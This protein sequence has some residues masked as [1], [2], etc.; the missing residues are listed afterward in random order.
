MGQF[1]YQTLYYF[2]DILLKIILGVVVVIYINKR[3]N[4]IKKKE[5]LY[6]LYLDL[7]KD[8]QNIFIY[9]NDCY[10]FSVYSLLEDRIRNS[11]EDNYTC[12]L[13]N[14]IISKY[15]IEY[16]EYDKSSLSFM[17]KGETINLILGDKKNNDLVHIQN[18]L[19]TP[20]LN[21]IQ[22]FEENYKKI[23]KFEEKF[24]EYLL[25]YR[26]GFITKREFEF[27]VD[28]EFGNF[29][30]FYWSKKK[31][32]LSEALQKYIITLRKRIDKL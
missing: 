16:N 4:Q 26:N 10:S 3:N 23:E 5:I 15:K 24:L 21:D 19:T 14:N 12:N 1:T 17:R 31:S 28:N 18:A 27:N 6:D 22:V 20:R 9:F 29:Y 13:I 2:L 25:A 32:E 11:D 30:S 7:I 8:K